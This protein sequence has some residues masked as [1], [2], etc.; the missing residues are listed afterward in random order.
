[1]DECTVLSTCTVDLSDKLPF[2]G[3]LVLG[4]ILAMSN[5]VIQRVWEIEVEGPLTAERRRVIRRW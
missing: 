5:R 1:M 3:W 4:W 2:E